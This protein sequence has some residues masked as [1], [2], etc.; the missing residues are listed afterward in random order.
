MSTTRQDL[1]LHQT[2]T[3]QCIQFLH[4][5][6]YLFPCVLSRVYLFVLAFDETCCIVP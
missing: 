1:K 3:D 6:F 4:G 2:Q 5:S